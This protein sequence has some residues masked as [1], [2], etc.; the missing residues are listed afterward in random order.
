MSLN[1]GPCT[2]LLP[3]PAW[4]HKCD[5]DTA[6]R[7]QLRS[8]PHDA[9]NAPTFDVHASCSRWCGGDR[10]RIV[11]SRAEIHTARRYFAWHVG[12]TNILTWRGAVQ[13]RRVHA[14]GPP[15]AG[16]NARCGGTNGRR[17][18][19]IC[20][21]WQ[22]VHRASVTS[23]SANVCSERIAK[24]I[25]GSYCAGRTFAGCAGKVFCSLTVEGTHL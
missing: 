12:H 20:T 25:V 11:H 1:A 14:P 6:Q 4:S 7:Q 3:S 8:V 17:R 18:N 19:L 2:Y 5:D 15:R 9:L 22:P 13:Q 16:R 24:L 23:G 10:E 21:R